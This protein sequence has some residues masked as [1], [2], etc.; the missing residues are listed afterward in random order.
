MRDEIL[1]WCWKQDFTFF[2][3]DPKGWKNVVEISTLKPLLKRP[4]SEFLINF[5]YDFLL[6]THTQKSFHED[7]RK[8]FGEAPDTSGMIPK[9]REKHLIDSYRLR[10]KEIAPSRGGKPRV[11][12]VP[13]LYPC[14]DRTLY[15]LVY[16]TR[17]AKG[18]VVFMEESEKLD[19]V[20][21]RVREQAK[22]QNREERTGQLE[23]QF[24]DNVKPEAQVDL[25]DVKDYWLNRL[26]TEPQLF[27]VE[28]LADMMEKTGLF[29]SDFQ[30][31]FIEWTEHT[32]NPAVGCSKISP[33]CAH[34][35]AEVMA[36][37]LK[38][39]GVKGYENGF[40][41]TLLPQRLEEPLERKQPTIYFVNSMSDLF[42]EQIPD[43]YIQDILSVIGR[44]PQHIFQILT[45]RAE[46]MA[47]FFQ[48]QVPPRNARLGT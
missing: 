2:F 22:Q 4:N 3:I 26:S 7:M 16:L 13:I 1:S 32:W 10:L 40:K 48:T 28:Q 12:H 8:I 46:R 27:G 33:G 11:A 25:K 18:L 9:E 31:A 29:E 34:C 14:R 47:D 45:K 24:H 44:A 43:S 42:H 23:F 17:H 20:Q 41:L 36:R 15:H 38:A 37:R 30:A 6:R 39:M 5:M 19:F 35:Y 21:R